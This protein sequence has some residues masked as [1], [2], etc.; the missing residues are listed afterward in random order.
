L[1]PLLVA[2][3]DRDVL[4]P[5]VGQSPAQDVRVR[6]LELEHRLVRG[7][8]LEPGGDR[9]HRG[10][11]E[12]QCLEFARVPVRGE[13]H[14]ST[15]L[16]HPDHF[17]QRGRLVGDEHDAELRACDVVGVVGDVEPVAIH[18][19]AFGVQ[20][21][22]CRSRGEV[23]DHPGRPVGRQHLGAE[24][25]RR[26]AQSAGAGG[27]VEECVALPDSGEPQSGEGQ[28]GFTRCDVLVVPCRDHV[29]RLDGGT[30]FGL[31]CR[32]VLHVC[33]VRLPSNALTT[34]R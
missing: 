33:H 32:L 22:G 21:F 4:Q 8:T 19:P 18:H 15:G 28:I 12:V 30:A 27:D 17:P 9:L 31:L 6:D 2:R 1:D 34:R 14:A 3:V 25:C 26:Q 10:D 29:P 23:L 11:E 5:R 7:G 24:P 13:E 20:P 16:R